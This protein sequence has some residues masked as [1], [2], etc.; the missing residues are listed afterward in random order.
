MW[1]DFV[2]AFTDIVT[3]TIKNLGMQRRYYAETVLLHWRKIVGEEIANHT[4]PAKIERGVLIV[5]TSSAVWSHHLMTL[6]EDIVTKINDFAGE[7]VVNDIKFQA[8]YLKKDQNED[9]T[10]ESEVSPISWKQAVLSIE[11][12]NSIDSIA[13]TLSN[14][15][16]RHKIKGILRK[17][18]ALRQVKSKKDWRNC[19]T[20]G[21]FCPPDEELCPVCTVEKRAQEKDKLLKL[22]VQAPWMSYQDCTQYVNCRLTGFNTAKN[23]LID[24]LTRN[25]DQEKS[26]DLTKATLVMLLNSIKPE[27]VTEEL[28]ASTM[29]KIRGK[30]HVFTPRR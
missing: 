17:D 23:E 8:G 24:R 10:S 2:K 9:N 19:S 30:K 3:L 5:G 25:L 14:D 22:L 28:I 27:G 29:D 7:K 1:S 4:S 6:K 26:D 16:L 21:I 15:A 11:D 20:C 13:E 12:M 18:L